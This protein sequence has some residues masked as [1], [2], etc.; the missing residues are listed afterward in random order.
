M[1][2]LYNG[3]LKNRVSGHEEDYYI[4]KLN[5]EHHGIIIELQR[6]VMSLMSRSDLFIGLYPEEVENML[7]DSGGIMIG[8]FVKDK[9]IGFYGIYFPNLNYDCLGIDLGIPEE[10]FTAIAHLEG[11][12]VHPDYRGNSI[13]KLFTGICIEEALK[14][15][16]IRYLCATVS[17]Y[18]LPSIESVFKVHLYIKMMKVKYGNMLRY[19]FVRDLENTEEIVEESIVDI[20]SNNFDLQSKLLQN[21]FV[22]FNL[23]NLHEKPFISFGKIKKY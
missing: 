21:G 13:Q 3:I 18:N 16:N 1:D 22:G 2:K 10:E 6:H 17:P 23:L 20:E 11:A 7:E 15:R 12:V 9:L 14:I 5:K 19:I 8:A 4:I